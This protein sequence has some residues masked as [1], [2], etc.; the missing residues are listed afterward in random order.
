MPMRILRRLYRLIR[1][2]VQLVFGIFLAL[3]YSHLV[4]KGIPSEKYQRIK[5]QWNRK[6]C[7]ILGL[8]IQVEGDIPASAS[9]L[10]S[11][12]IS[13]LDIPLLG[14]LLPLNF[15]SKD[16]VRRWP[17][18]GWLAWKSG[19]LFIKRGSDG[20]ANQASLEITR[21]LKAGQNVLIFPEGTTTDGTRVRRFHPRLFA[22]AIDNIVSIQPVGIRYIDVD[23]GHCHTAAFIDEEPFTSNLWKILG[24]P[25]IEAHVYFLPTIKSGH[26]THRRALAEATRSQIVK[27]LDLPADH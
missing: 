20:A 27:A 9:L 15:L 8:K 24:E 2:A 14:S 23:G 7:D 26:D 5:Q 4:E 10:V 17:V 19:T 22:V 13:W 16:E 18:V 6:T 3:K 25:S 12:H 11:N 21:H 1:L